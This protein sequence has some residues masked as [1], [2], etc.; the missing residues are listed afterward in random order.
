MRPY[1]YCL[2]ECGGSEGE[3]FSWE[4][5]ETVGDSSSDG[6]WPCYES[7]SNV[8]ESKTEGVMKLN[9]AT[10]VD[11]GGGGG[12]KAS[13]KQSGDE[14]FSGVSEDKISESEGGVLLPK[15]N[16]LDYGSL[17]SGDKSAESERKEEVETIGENDCC[18]FCIIC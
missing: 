15:D 7:F 18:D 6:V 12:S 13:P 11:Y 9:V 16:Q 5:D 14:S 10:L 2:T 3:P 8:D 17:R 4:D 1:S